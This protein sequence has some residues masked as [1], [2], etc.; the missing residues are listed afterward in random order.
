MT[1]GT[2][3]T[4][5]VTSQQMQAN[6]PRIVMIILLLIVAWQM[7]RLTLGIIEVWKSPDLPETISLSSGAS[8]QESTLFDWKT[9]PLFGEVITPRAGTGSEPA[10][11]RPATGQLSRMQ[12]EVVGIVDSSS[13][14]DSYIVLKEK[15]ETMVLQEGDEIRDGITVKLIETKSFVAT[16]GTGD[17]VF[18]IEM[19]SEGSDIISPDETSTGTDEAE[20]E[21][22]A[23]DFRVTNQQVLDKIDE[24]KTTLAS[25]PLELVGQIRAQPVPRDGSTYGYRVYPGRD[26]ALLTGVGLRPGDILIS[27]NDTPLSD[28]GQLD[29][30]INSLSQSNTIQLTI[31][32]GGKIRDINV[33]LEN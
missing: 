25:N 26:R 9:L 8:Q 24:Y 32:R 19:L 15:G 30:I 3:N 16:D 18:E 27:V 21:Q 31:E 12:L 4:S 28:I 17:K 2:I 33:V 1:L 22:P 20:A 14:G 5:S 10:R 6:A 29:T 11:P 7:A 13:P 23:V